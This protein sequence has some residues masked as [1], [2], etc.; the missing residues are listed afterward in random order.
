MS[1]VAL[2]FQPA[3]E[4]VRTARLVAVAVARRAGLDENRLDEV[5]LAVGEVCARAVRRSLETSSGGG[6][7]VEI[8]DRGPRFEVTVTDHADAGEGDD[9]YISLALVR[10]L[11]DDMAV[12]DGPGGQ[13]GVIRISWA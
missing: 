5:R 2:R 13:G 3:A 9:E 11:S 4:N 1:T 8:D 6:V 12:L 10:G 7:L